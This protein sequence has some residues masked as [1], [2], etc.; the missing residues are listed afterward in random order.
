MGGHA[1]NVGGEIDVK[2]TTKTT[3]NPDTIATAIVGHFVLTCEGKSLDNAELVAAL[4]RGSEVIAEDLLVSSTADGV[5]EVSWDAPH[6][7][8][9]EGHY[10]WDVY[11]ETDK[12][13]VVESKGAIKLEPLFSA[14][15]YHDGVVSSGLP[16]S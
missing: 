1:I 7:Q 5:Y 9:S 12:S 8:L 16:I 2:K 6:K 13:R 3:D 14:S 10:T 11:R 4:R 15:F